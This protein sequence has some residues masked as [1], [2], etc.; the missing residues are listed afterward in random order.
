MEAVQL[1]F[2]FNVVDKSSLVERAVEIF[3]RDPYI[4]ATKVA[5]QLGVCRVTLDWALKKA[6]ISRRAKRRKLFDNLAIRN[7]AIRLANAMPPLSLTKIAKRLGV[8]PDVVKEF[9]IENGI[10]YKRDPSFAVPVE[11]LACKTVAELAEDYGVNRSTARIAFK[12]SGVEPIKHLFERLAVDPEFL[13]EARTMTVKDLAAARGIDRKTVANA[14]AKAGV[15]P[16]TKSSGRIES[17][18]KLREEE[19]LAWHVI[20][21]RLGIH[22]NTAS[23]A[24]KKARGRVSGKRFYE[25]M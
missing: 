21:E 1:H 16:Y 12:R 10:E 7:E 13:R 14:L 3:D 8:S 11:E 19:H 18:I 15:K 22:P 23:T 24:Y 6:G 2:R 9:Y 5:K 20:G 25:G 4:S 17:I